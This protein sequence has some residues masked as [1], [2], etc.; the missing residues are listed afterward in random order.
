MH[1]H[2]SLYTLDFPCVL[3]YERAFTIKK[4]PRNARKNMC[5]GDDH[6][7]WKHLL[8]LEVCRGLRIVGGY[9][10]FC[11]GSS[12]PLILSYRAT[13]TFQ[14][15]LDLIKISFPHVGASVDLESCLG[16]NWVRLPSPQSHFGM[17]RY[18]YQFQHTW[19]VCLITFKSVPTEL[20]LYSVSSSVS[21]FIGVFLCPIWIRLRGLELEAG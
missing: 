12:N 8:S 21:V 3:R 5:G 10:H 1:P 13:S 14:V 15:S 9:D 6:L 4:P 19:V 7:A 17:I 18:E 16:Y 20:L 2:P 11:Q